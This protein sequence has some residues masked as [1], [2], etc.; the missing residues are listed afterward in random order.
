M[1]GDDDDGWIQVGK[2]VWP[3]GNLWSQQSERMFYISKSRKTKLPPYINASQIL[4]N[5][6]VLQTWLTHVKKESV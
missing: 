2:L 3:G 4:N 6:K 5:F 1:D